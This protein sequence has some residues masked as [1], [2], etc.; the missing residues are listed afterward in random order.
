M[1]A[2]MKSGPISG[3]LSGSV[4]GVTFSHN[5]YGRYVRQR[6]VP[7]NPSTDRQSAARS[8]LSDLSKNFNN[9]LTQAQR[10]AWNLYG[11]SVDW[12]NS[13]GESIFLSGI[14]H[15]IRSNS[16]IL[17]AGGVRVDDGP[18]IFNTGDVDPTVVPLV[19]EAGQEIS[20][21]FDD[22][23]AWLDE[24]NAFMMVG[25]SQPKDP[26]VEFIGSPVRFA[27]SLAGD[28]VTPL[29]TPQ[30]IPVPYVVSEG[31]RVQVY[32]RIARA[33]GRL[34][35]KFVRTVLVTA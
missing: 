4:G 14:N 28:A 18:V 34:S 32:F 19:E 26:A 30:L 8:K 21:A 1:C 24:D 5:R 25:M 23:M 29:T 3:D 22:T 16:S 7:V 27:G 10:T 12:S 13:L 35:E 11:S 20:V 17:Q 31:Q 2:L 6:V 15:Y 9:L 33:D